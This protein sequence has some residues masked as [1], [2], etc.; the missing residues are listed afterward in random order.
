MKEEP[1][2]MKCIASDMDGTLLNEDQKISEENRKALEAVRDMGG[3]V[4]I[5]TG[6]SFK[7]ARLVLDEINFNCPII[8]MN[9]AAVY[10][11]KGELITSQ[12]ISFE[13]LDSAITFLEEAGL[14]FELYTNHGVF[15]KNPERAIDSLVDIVLS[16]NPE[17]DRE[18]VRRRALARIEYGFLFETQDYHA[19]IKEEDM[20]VF[21]ILVFS[22]Y[23]DQLSQAAQGLA[24]FDGLTITSSGKGNIE[25]NHRGISKGNAL[26]KLLS[27]YGI[28]LEETI[29]IGDN[30][31]DVS[32]FEKAGLS[33]AMGNA[34]EDIKRICKD[35]TLS[36]KE[37]GVAHAIYR[38]MVSKK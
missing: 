8:S 34:R 19:L 21:K 31:N 23:K 2:D 15:S 3:Q 35:T 6:R 20:Q 24:R 38:Y 1:N 30:L 26:E 28:P 16:A 25:I 5:A 11:Q 29:A 18:D 10:D 13:E 4:I 17:H 36:N 32:M 12:P 22:L 9:G 14:Y 37:D 7:E 27:Q 33:I